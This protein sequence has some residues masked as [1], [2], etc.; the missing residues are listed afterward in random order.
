MIERTAGI[1]D[2][3]LLD[4]ATYAAKLIPLQRKQSEMVPKLFWRMGCV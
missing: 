1:S 2:L 3:L 4:C